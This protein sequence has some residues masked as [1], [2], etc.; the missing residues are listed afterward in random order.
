M[1]SGQR[2]VNFLLDILF[3]YISNVSPFPGFLTANPYPILLPLLLMRVLTPNP[4]HL[5][6][7]AF[8]YTGASSLHNGLSS[9]WC[10]I[11][12][13]S[14]AYVAGAMGPAP[15]VP[16][17]WWFSPWKLRCVWLV[18]IIVLLTGLQTTSAHSVL[19][20]AAPLWSL[21]SLQY[22]PVS[23][24]ICICLLWQI[25]SGDSYIRFQSASTSWHPQYY[26]GLVSVY[27]MNLHVG[28]SLAGLSFSLCTTLFP[29]FL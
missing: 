7:L 16:F 9:H 2:R 8:P 19:S 24:H 15:W 18:D 14:V 25:L 21:C 6:A 3:I 23:I 1:A 26:L 13:S 27:G 22:L 4:S 12:P 20:L 10:Q 11:R 28:Q 29:Y 17:G 5:I